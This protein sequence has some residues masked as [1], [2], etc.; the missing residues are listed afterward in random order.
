[1]NRKA[2]MGD[3]VVMLVDGRMLVY[4]GLGEPPALS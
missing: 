2:A 1:M 3:A 4:T